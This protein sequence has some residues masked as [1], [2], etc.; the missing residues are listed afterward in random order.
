MGGPAIG[1]PSITA[2]QSSQ[3][4]LR[5]LK[6]G[7]IPGPD[8]LPSFEDLQRTIG[9]Q[10]Y[11]RE[12]DRYSI[13]LEASI[14]VL[15]GY[16]VTITP[17]EKQEEEKGQVE[18]AETPATEPKRSRAVSANPYWREELGGRTAVDAEP[19]RSTPGDSGSPSGA[20]VSKQDG[21][22]PVL[23]AEVLSSKDDVPDFSGTRRV[24]WLRIKVTSA[25]GETKLETK[26]PAGFLEGVASFIPEVRGVDLEALVSKASGKQRRDVRD[27]IF[28]LPIE[29]DV[30]E[31]FLE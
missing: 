11:F 26:I 4:A 14:P 31:I 20:L 22:G 24:S 16:R 8:A 27:P 30:L 5:G 12:S 25:S 18:A 10:D 23:E 6:T 28:T 7:E 13:P 17:L 15:P 2:I 1:S 21:R 19:V 9:F 29:G 3:V